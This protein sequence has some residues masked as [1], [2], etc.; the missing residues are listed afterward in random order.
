MFLDELGQITE[1]EYINDSNKWI[2]N[3]LYSKNIEYMKDLNVKDQNNVDECIKCNNDL[4]KRK[5]F[6][7]KIGGSVWGFMDCYIDYPNDGSIYINYFLVDKNYH[8]IEF[9]MEFMRDFT[10]LALKEYDQIVL[11]KF[12]N[13][14]EVIRFWNSLGFDVA[15]SPNTLKILRRQQ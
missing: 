10:C 4:G 15:N 12:A 14:P 11:S 13:K 8:N 6:Y 5:A 2:L 9:G 3:D 7:T 1:I